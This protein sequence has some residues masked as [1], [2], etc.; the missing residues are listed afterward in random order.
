MVL[1]MFILVSCTNNQEN[2]ILSLSTYE[3][4]L[5]VG[6]TLQ[7]N[8]ELKTGDKVI[9]D[10]INWES[11]NEGVATIQTGLVRA[12]SEG[13]TTIKATY[14]TLSQSVVITVT[15]KSETS[16][17]VSFNTD[18]GTV[19]EPVNVLEDSIIT[20]PANPTKEGHSFS[21]WY[22]DEEFL[23]AF[24]FNDVITSDLVL[25]AKFIPNQYRITF[26]T[27]HTTLKEDILIHHGNTLNEE[28]LTLEAND[29]AVSGWYLDSEL[30]NAFN[31]ET[32]ITNDLTLYA[33][34][35]V[36]KN[37]YILYNK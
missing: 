18:G 11:T 22:I 8:H 26:T 9:N 14:K 2:I 3:E 30:K 16:Y 7:I 37:K 32:V 34:W 36:K 29:K 31:L 15:K 35:D 17:T 23:E 27:N 21:N 4:A 12:L 19:I 24:D 5:E 20:R 10:T 28:Q 6:Q 25:Y 1:S 13:T 33:K